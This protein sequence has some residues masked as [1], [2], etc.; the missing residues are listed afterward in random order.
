VPKALLNDLG[1]LTQ[2]QQQQGGVCHPSSSAHQVF[3]GE[4]E[5]PR[6]G[7]R[8]GGSY[9]D[10]RPRGE[11][12]RTLSSMFLSYG[13]A[14]ATLA[15]SSSAPLPSA[16]ASTL[17]VRGTHG[18]DPRMKCMPVPHDVLVAAEVLVRDPPGGPKNQ[19]P[20]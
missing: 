15:P 12:V 13:S 10:G 18:T 3:G 16:H 7:K 20:G 11:P 17:S 4:L 1:V 8:T 2:L 6:P 9:G 19:C 14:T 5:A